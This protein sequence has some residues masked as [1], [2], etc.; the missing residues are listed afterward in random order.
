MKNRALYKWLAFLLAFV[1][2]LGL[3]ACGKSEPAPTPAPEPEEEPEPSQSESPDAAE[4]AGG[5]ENPFPD[6]G[7]PPATT[8]YVLNHN[9]KK[10][11]RPSCQ[12]VKK[13]AAHNREDVD[14]TRENIIAQGYKPCK[15]CKP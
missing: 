2:I 3:C 14:D 4:G 6:Q 8:A 1:M 5:T 12:H 7:L 10:F 11:H 13:I 15:V 9:T